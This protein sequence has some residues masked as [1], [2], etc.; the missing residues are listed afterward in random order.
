MAGESMATELVHGPR[1]HDIGAGGVVV[2]AVEADDIRIQ[3]VDGTE[4][5]VVAPADGVGIAT[6]ARPGRFSVRTLRHVGTDRT[7]FVGLTIGRREFGFPLGFRVSGTIEIEVPRDASVEVGAAAGDVTVRDVRGGTVI[8]TA[9]GDV[10]VKGAGGRIAV[11]VASG[12]VNVIGTEPVS[13]EV[14]S[15]AGDV[16]ARAPRFERVAIETIS[17]DAEL[18]GAFGAGANHAISTVSGDV[19]LAVLGGGLT[20]EVKTVSGDVTCQHPDRRDGDGRRRPLV[21]GDGAAQMAIRSMSGDV[22]VRA[23]RVGSPAPVPPTAPEP[24]RPPAPPPAPGGV[25][26]APGDAQDAGTM[27][28]LEALA[29]GEI[30]VLEAERRLAGA[31]AG[32]EATPDA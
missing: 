26:E 25:P 9:S 12:D 11:N 3:G 13:L 22:D 31:P 16:R 15:V 20:I 17:G 30:D 8:R 19:E 1:V 14:H 28:V 29:R 7:G 21:I 23:G 10:S 18:A 6:E 32:Q 2:I 24:P 27:T 5:R 4:V